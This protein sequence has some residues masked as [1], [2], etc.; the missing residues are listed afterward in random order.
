MQSTLYF[1]NND[2]TFKF[3]SNAE[4]ALIFNSENGC[5]GK[6]SWGDGTLKF[7]G[8][9]DD[10]AKILFDALMCHFFAAFEEAV[11][12]RVKMLKP[13]HADGRI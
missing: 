11:E 3:Q 1:S 8:S 12:N 10:S 4:G 7:E 13:S 5:V 2:S 9:A 6:L